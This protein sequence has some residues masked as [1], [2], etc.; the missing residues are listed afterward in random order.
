MCRKTCEKIFVFSLLILLFISCGDMGTIFP[1][2]SS[3]YQVSA[4]VNDSRIRDNS[5]IKTGDV[6][7]P[8][9]QNPIS[10]DPDL[11]GLQ[12]YIE[13]S[14]GNMIGEAV[15]YSV[16]GRS[17][18][19]RGIL[20]QIDD[21]DETFPAFPL[22]DDLKLG[23]YNLVFKALSGGAVLH[24]SSQIIY[25]VSNL[26]ISIDEISVYLPGVSD[27]PQLIPPDITV[28]LDVAITS[29]EGFDPY[30]IWYNGE[31]QIGEGPLSEG[32]HRL[33][34]TIPET[35][36]FQT[37]RAE[38]FPFIADD[39]SLK[40]TRGIIKELSLPIS[41]KAAVPYSFGK[42]DEDAL[43]WYQFS[44][45]LEA[46]KE[47]QKNDAVLVKTQSSPPRWE[48]L[49]QVYGLLIGEDDSYDIPD[50]SIILN[51]ESGR[52]Y[53]HYTLNTRFAPKSQG[54]LFHGS[55]KTSGSDL[56]SL[57]LEVLLE[58]KELVLSI[59][60]GL[61]VYEESIPMDV[62]THDAFIKTS[63]HFY[64]Y[65]ND[66][67]AYLELLDPALATRIIAIPYKGTLSGD[68]TFRFGAK[69]NLT[70]EVMLNE[71]KPDIAIID[72]FFLEHSRQSIGF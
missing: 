12:V 11:T 58:E 34:W 72:E 66:F 28:L 13:D 51:G 61:S 71:T 45:N 37:I 9:F 57:I 31:K 67:S 23:Q 52:E 38:V 30:I 46:S 62:F 10:N 8:A 4:Y 64:A 17:D 32:Y 49:S 25:Y 21:F 35:V 43:Y 3:N 70:Q 6:I 27:G 24:E 26:N 56:S 5:I 29:D 2:G 40:N 39:E 48:P 20:R 22:P 63:L 68:G 47:S 1:S 19:N 54:T 50:F 65:Q 55:F 16:S 41:D 42:N 60:N 15:H 69:P 14:K 36:G 7:R 44:G 53:D 33:L 59:Q 18:V